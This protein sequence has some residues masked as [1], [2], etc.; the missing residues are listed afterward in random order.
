MKGWRSIVSPPPPIKKTLDPILFTSPLSKKQRCDKWGYMAIGAATAVPAVALPALF[1]G[2]ADATTPWRE[3]YWV[4]ATIWVAIFSHIGNYFWTH[5]FYTLLGAEYTFPAH[6]L[7]DVPFC[8]YL[9]THAY[10]LF[11]HALANVVQRV[12]RRAVL[13]AGGGRV[14]AG[15]A[16]AAAVAALAY[17]TAYG[18]TATIAH[19]PHYRFVDR[20]RM[21]TV[22]SLFYAIY[23][24]VSF[25]WFFAMDE[26]EEEGGKGKQSAPKWTL[27]RAATDA[28]AAGMLVTMLL[29][30]WRLGVGGI[31]PAKRKRWGGLPWL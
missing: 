17:L 1:P 7:N 25:P 26:E 20:G 15:A 10:F 24:F 22:G 14:A 13:R 12:A 8:L 27:R 11:Y 21:Y 28:L 29:D 31:V 6:R 18:E 16:Q 9:M 23:F 4:K 5:Y 30:A 3:R 19:F 2:R